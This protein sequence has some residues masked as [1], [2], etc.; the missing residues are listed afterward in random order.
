M[1]DPENVHTPSLIMDSK[2]DAV[3]PHA[4]PPQIRKSLQLLAS[5]WPRIFGEC[6][7]LS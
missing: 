6:K 5:R 2:Y 7:N 4:D 3:I 1:P